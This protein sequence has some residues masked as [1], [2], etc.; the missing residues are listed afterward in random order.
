MAGT[1][2]PPEV[3][4]VPANEASWE[5]LQAVFGTRGDLVQMPVPAV[6]DAAQGVLGLGRAPMSLAARFR[7]QTELRS[8]RVGH[9]E[10]PSRLPAASPWAGARWSRARHA[11]LLRVYRVPWD[12]RAEDKADETVWA[13]TC[14]SPAR[15]SRRRG[16]SSIAR[17]AAVDFARRGGACA[18]GLPACHGGPGRASSWA[19]STSAA[20]ASFESAGSPRSAG[21]PPGAS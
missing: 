16:V 5:D 7:E 6:Q 19:S 12:G 18:R 20:A 13:V 14:S 15:V 9:D 1:A 8:R 4:I 21:R 3:T 17:G 11:R 2:T 10:R